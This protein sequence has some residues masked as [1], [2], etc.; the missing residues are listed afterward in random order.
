MDNNE[1]AKRLRLHV[2]LAKETPLDVDIRLS[3]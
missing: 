3:V 1:I 2:V